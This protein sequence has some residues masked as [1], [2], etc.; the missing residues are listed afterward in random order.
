MEHTTE[1]PKYLFGLVGKDIDYSF[2]RVYFSKKF[3]KESLNQYSYTNFDIATIEDFENV[4]SKNPNIC[5]LNVT[6]PYKE[7]IIP[8]LDKIDKKALK[9]GAINTIKITKKGQYIGYNTD[10]FGFQKTLKPHL[11]KHHKR[12]LI[13]GTGGA[14][15]AVAYTLKKL[16]IKFQYVSRTISEQAKYS[17]ETLSEADIKK[18]TLIINTTPLGTFPNIDIAPTIPYNSITNKHLVFDLIYNPIETKFLNLAKQ[19]GA[20]TLN[21]LP[22]LEYQAEKA[23]KIWNKK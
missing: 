16:G 20:Q 22:M 10:W 3:E 11:K 4:L 2:S 18:H 1:K 19:Q 13:L 7:A 6:I 9:I 23:W 14:S 17:Y 15:K 12:A 21:G 8:Y 5:S